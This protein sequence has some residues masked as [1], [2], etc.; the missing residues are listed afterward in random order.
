M[1]QTKAPGAH[2]RRFAHHTRTGRERDAAKFCSRIAFH[3][4]L[5][6]E[7]GLENRRFNIPSDVQERT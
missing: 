7:E 1:F 5:L 4:F 6:D 2:Q 3:S